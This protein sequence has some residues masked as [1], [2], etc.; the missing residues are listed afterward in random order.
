MITHAEAERKLR[1]IDPKINWD[2]EV[3]ACRILRRETQLTQHPAGRGKSYDDTPAGKGLLHWIENRLAQPHLGYLD[4]SQVNEV[5]G[6]STTQALQA[7]GR[8]YHLAV[9][10]KNPT[11]GADFL[12]AILDGTRPNETPLP[13]ANSY[14]WLK[15]QVL[16]Q[17]GFIWTDTPTQ[18]NVIGIR[19]YM[20]P[21]GT[22]PNT[23][24]QW[25]DTIFVA[26][27]DGTGKKQVK[28]WAASTD[29]GI[30]YYHTRPLNPLGCA[31]LVAPQQVRY[32][33]GPHG[34]QGM[35][36]FVQDSNV[37]VARTNAANYTDQSKR[38]T[39]TPQARFWINLH[40]GFA[41]SESQ[42]VDY[43]S[44]GCQ[45]T[46]GAGWGDWRWLSLRDLLYTDPRKHFLYTLLAGNALKK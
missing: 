16:E 9:D 7:L 26:W 21:A 36:A 29:P 18:L 43:S 41:Y 46:K 6:G 10:L 32:R 39:D 15:T 4:P 1:I 35:P 2:V 14:D 5:W 23:G 38:Y 37:T 40:A 44:A 31:H 19:G 22:V 30:Y 17:P 34:S 33:P 20:V 13:A 12:R 25:N 27:I 24:N 28:A 45:T 3:L 42:G 8:N 11:I